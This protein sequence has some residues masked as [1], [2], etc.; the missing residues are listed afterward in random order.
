M[1]VQRLILRTLFFPVM[2]VTIGI[3]GLFGFM[4]LEPFQ[5][6]LGGPPSSLGWGTPGGTVMTFASVGLV[7][8]LLV[9]AIW[10]VA[11]PIRNDRRQQFRR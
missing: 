2:L 9:I 6:A 11:A 1:S 5:A 7:T 8:L 3:I 4:V 10:Y